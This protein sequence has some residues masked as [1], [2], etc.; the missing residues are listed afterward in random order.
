MNISKEEDFMY[1]N[2]DIIKAIKNNGVSEDYNE[3]FNEERY[4]FENLDV[5]KA[6]EKG[7][8]KSGFEH[9]VKFGYFE[10]HKP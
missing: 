4:L 10:G 5:A 3:S 6:I 1:R 2:P 9:Y 8:F 7:T